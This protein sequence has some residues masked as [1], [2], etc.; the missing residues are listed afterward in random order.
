MIRILN[1]DRYDLHLMIIIFK[2]SCWLHFKVSS[3]ININHLNLDA[4]IK[5]LEEIRRPPNFCFKTGSSDHEA[6][7][8]LEKYS[9]DDGRKVGKSLNRNVAH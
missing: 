8:F 7:F 3:G 4:T 1:S 9:C 5:N 2:H 6:K